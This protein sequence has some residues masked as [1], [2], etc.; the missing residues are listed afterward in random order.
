MVIRPLTK[1]CSVLKRHLAELWASEDLSKFNID[2]FVK[3]YHEARD[4]SEVQ[5]S[6]RPR[7]TN[8]EEP[9]SSKG[10][11]N[12]ILGGSKLCRDSISAIKKHRR[13]VL[14][15]SSLSEEV[16][17]QGASISFDGKETRHLE[18][19][20]DDALVI[21]LD[22][23]N[24]EVSRILV[25]TVSS[26]DLIFLGTL[27]RMGISRVDIV[28]PPSPLVAFTSGSTMS[29]RTIKLPVLAGKMSKIVDFVVFDKPA[30]Y[31]IILGTPWIYQMKAIPFTYHQC[32]KF[33]TPSGVE[34]IRGDQEASRTCY[35]ASHRLKIQ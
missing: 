24:F 29:L 9:R 7:L 32:I 3:K 21:T 17:Y 19:P 6:K 1:D 10:K 25:D 11:I 15:K 30:A 16:N 35:M 18:R 14:L 8:E 2:D 31:N 4:N 27:E 26:V 5:N 13:N 34:T 20:H 12:V 23:A 33:P 22:V 28:G